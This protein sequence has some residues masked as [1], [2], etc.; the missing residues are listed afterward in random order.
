MG[1][2]IEITHRQFINIIAPIYIKHNKSLYIQGSPGVGKSDIVKTVAKN[3]AKARGLEFVEWNK[4][5]DLQKHALCDGYTLTEHVQPANT[6]A[7]IQPKQQGAASVQASV[8]TAR[9]LVGQTPA[10]KGNP[11]LKTT[12]PS[13]EDNAIDGQEQ[14]PGLG[15]ASTPAKHRIEEVYIFADLRLS[16]KDST[17]I[18]GMPS[19]D[20]KNNISRWC[21]PL[22]MKVLSD[23]RC[24]GLL[25]LD[26]L[27][28]APVLT[29]NAAYSLVLDRAAGEVTFSKNVAVFGAGNRVSDKSGVFERPQALKNRFG[30]YTLK[31]PSATD[32]VQDYARYNN[33]DG[34]IVGFIQFKP[35]LLNAEGINHNEQDSVNTPR[36]VSDAGELINGEPDVNVCAMIVAGQCGQG[37]ANTWADWCNI[38][39][40][41]NIPR[42]LNGQDP[43]PADIG[44]RWFMISALNDEVANIYKNGNTSVIQNYTKVLA[45]I[46]ADLQ[47][48]ACFSIKDAIPKIV[49]E[50]LQYPDGM[51]IGKQINQLISFQ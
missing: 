3:E 8:D 28:N 10:I 50:L 45:Q 43:V 16:Q 7:H 34:R 41:L 47:V 23:Q 15:M 29:Q 9:K 20:N 32:W 19:V 31:S 5:T 51:A 26:E 1:R 49:T 2:S 22:L 11:F 48:S 25:F 27:P 36:S 38:G 12:K 30:N 18:G 17:D 14:L 24:Q 21:P 35:E 4:L 37:F 42:I 39:S 40:T 44:A 46:D 13:V 33:I 6:P